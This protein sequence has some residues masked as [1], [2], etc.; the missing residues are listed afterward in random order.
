MYASTTSKITQTGIVVK[1]IEPTTTTSLG[2]ALIL[3]LYLHG[4]QRMNV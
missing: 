2:A 1:I 3:F 4:M